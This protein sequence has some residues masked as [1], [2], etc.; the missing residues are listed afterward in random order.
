MTSDAKQATQAFQIAWTGYIEQLRLLGFGHGAVSPLD[1]YQYHASKLSEVAALRL[2]IARTFLDQAGALMALNDEFAISDDPNVR[3]SVEVFVK[4][5][6]QVTRNGSLDH[7][8]ISTDDR[9]SWLADLA[10]EASWAA[11][12]LAQKPSNQFGLIRYNAYAASQ[13][14]SAGIVRYDATKLNQYR[15][16]SEKGDDWFINRDAP[17]IFPSVLALCT[18]PNVTIEKTEGFFP[19]HGLFL[20]EDFRPHT[21]FDFRSNGVKSLRCIPAGNES[22]VV[23]ASVLRSYI[24]DGERRMEVSVASLP[25]HQ[26]QAKGTAKKPLRTI[27]YTVDATWRDRKPKTPIGPGSDFPQETDVEA[28]NESTHDAFDRRGA[29]VK[30]K[31]EPHQVSRM[32]LSPR[33][34]AKHCW[35]GWRVDTR[36]FDPEYQRTRLRPLSPDPRIQIRMPAGARPDLPKHFYP[37]DVFADWQTE[38]DADHDVLNR[39]SQVEAAGPEQRSSFSNNDL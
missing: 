37:M 28:S 19:F 24:L 11:D 13:V 6:M 23:L 7:P 12:R 9:R 10:G 25:S 21:V 36:V 31:L 18:T 1:S 30:Y 5:A 35:I 4:A 17:L 3:R 14:L 22:P 32:G 2:R 39:T 8:T 38:S 20:A 15:A 26:K 27:A 29:W 16:E 33:R 34:N